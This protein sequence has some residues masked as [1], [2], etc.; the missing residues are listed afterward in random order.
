MLLT[1]HELDRLLIF[2]AA[3]LARSRQARGLLLNAPE[4]IAIIADTACE[5]ARDGLTLSAAIE[6]STREL[7][8]QDVL[9]GVTLLLPEF[10]D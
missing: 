9:P 8:A 6:L 7:D 1:P 5:A 10:G 4:A 3:S 2:Q